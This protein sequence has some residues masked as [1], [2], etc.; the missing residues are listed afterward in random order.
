VT[1][2]LAGFLL[3]LGW[4]L[5]W[6]ATTS[7]EK[8]GTL[9]NQAVAHLL[10][11]GLYKDYPRP[12]LQSLGC[13]INIS[14]Q[15][16]RL[17]F[18][19]S[20]LFLL[21]ALVIVLY[22]RALYA[23]R[24]VEPFESVVFS[25]ITERPISLSLRLPSEVHKEVGPITDSSGLRQ[26]WRLRAAQ[27]GS[28][29]VAVHGQGET[30]EKI[31][32]VGSD[33]KSLNP[34]LGRSWKDWL[35]RFIEKPLPGSSVKEIKVNYPRRKQWLGPYPVHWGVE[36]L[37]SFILWLMLL[38]LVERQLRRRQGLHRRSESTGAVTS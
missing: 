19:P 38:G 32:V 25:A 12:M 7:Q 9:R 15:I 20:L 26:F 10:E 34:R 17:L 23:H 28:Y 31:L 14:G 3:A 1:V 11:I 33:P 4:L 2:L 30:A 29:V 36:L 5:I 21:P 35:L 16:M 6:R 22:T 13:L 8:A 24:P 37:L 27:A 18:L